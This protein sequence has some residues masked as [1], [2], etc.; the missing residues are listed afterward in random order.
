[1]EATRRGFLQ[2]LAALAGG[3]LVGLP[4]G[5][6]KTAFATVRADVNELPVQIV[7][8]DVN[9]LPVQMGRFGKIQIDAIW[10]SLQYASL[11]V[12]RRKSS[13]LGNGDE[14]FGPQGWTLT[15]RVLGAMPETT[16]LLSERRQIP[17]AFYP[18]NSLIYSGLGYLTDV[19]VT[20]D[21]WLETDFVL[22][23]I[24]GL[25]TGW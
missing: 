13:I 10:Y 22:A 9:E 6:G 4:A 1:M 23:G 21:S 17:I 11:S 14:V 20:L 12:D 16:E 2:G 3:A 7:R 25:V 15:G 19:V 24:D 8:A 18:D 5:R